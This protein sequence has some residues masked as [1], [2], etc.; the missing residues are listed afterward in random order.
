M[1]RKTKY[2]EFLRNLEELMDIERVDFAKA[3]GKQTTNLS[4]Y[5]SGKKKLGKGVIRNAIRNLSEWQVTSFCEVE[6]IP[7]PLTS[8]PTRPGIYA[9]Y[10]EAGNTLY[11]GQAKNL[12][13]ETNQTLNRQVN[14]PIRLGPALSKKR[15]PKYKEVAKRLSVYVVESSRLRQNLEAILL[16]VFPNQSHNNKLGNFR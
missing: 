10:D 8:I 12:R 1:G 14:F 16:R 3:L 11:V 2:V 13:A 6:K 5:F 7:D 9:L 15:K 4:Q